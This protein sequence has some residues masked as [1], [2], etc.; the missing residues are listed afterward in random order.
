[1]YKPRAG[2]NDEP[3]AAP[4]SGAPSP[5][6]WSSSES[7]SASPAGACS[8]GASPE[9]PF[10]PFTVS[11][12]SLQIF[13]ARTSHTVQLLQ[14]L[15]RLGCHGGVWRISVEWEKKRGTTP[16]GANFAAIR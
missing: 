6:S 1:M 2:K 7:S 4:A 14:L 16:V 10:W 15:C 5:S 3:P 12:V 8:A 9:A 13:L 11:G